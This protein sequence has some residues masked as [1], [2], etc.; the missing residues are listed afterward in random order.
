M[1]DVLQA[2][3]HL[4]QVSIDVCPKKKS[5]SEKQA[6]SARRMADNLQAWLVANG[7]DPLRLHTDVCVAPADQGTLQVKGTQPQRL[8]LRIV[9]L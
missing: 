3:P 1:V 2:A 7:V 4:K 6:K 9:S 8:L 5:P